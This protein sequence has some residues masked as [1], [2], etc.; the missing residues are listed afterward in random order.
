MGGDLTAP[1]AG[2]A[3][4]LLIRAIRDPDGANLDRLQVIKGWRDSGGDLHEQIYDVACSDGRAIVARRCDRPVGNTVNVASASYRNDIG[5]PYLAAWW[6]DPDFDA[7]ESAFYYVRVIEIPT[8]SWLAYDKAHYGA[9]VDLPDDAVLVQQE[10][11]YT[12][13]IWY[14]P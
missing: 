8:P 9:A 5:A 10:R 6:R 14:R 3:P 4:T 11:A 12:S 13:P 2:A 1:P 7:A